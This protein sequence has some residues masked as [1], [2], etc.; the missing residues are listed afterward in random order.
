MVI[1]EL[2]PPN[3][4]QVNEFP[5]NTIFQQLSNIINNYHF[6]K[7]EGQK[8]LRSAM[9][10]R[11][12]NTFYI[13][14]KIHKKKIGTRPITASHSYML[15][16]ISSAVANRLQ[17]EVQKYPSIAKNTK[18]VLQRLETTTLP[19]ECFLVTYD[20]ERLYPSINLRQAI[21]IISEN[22]VKN[23][24]DHLWIKLLQ[25]IM[26]NNYVK[27][28]G[29]IYHQTTGT[30]TG[31]QVAPQFANLYLHFLFEKIMNNDAILFNSRYIDD[32]FMIIKTNQD[33][34]HILNQINNISNLNITYEIHPTSAIYLDLTI[35]KGLRF[36]Y[37]N[38]LDVTTYFKPTN[39]LLY[40]PYSSCHPDHMKLGIAKGEAIRLLRNNCHKN[41]WIKQCTIVF[42]GL[43]AR[44]YPPYKIKSIW[45]TIR[46]EDRNK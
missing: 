21:Q 22:I 28:S 26:F 38:I 11:E 42:K 41:N 31:T 45:K 24:S 39:K 25:L 1:Q 7:F 29:K 9:R 3:F 16:D 34:Q 35:Y 10:K 8:W 44:G 40:L 36:K 46:F 27:Y 5:Y 20:V 12:P 17:Y 15:S 2:Q 6:I 32:G 13:S 14:P 4:Q 37:K 18:S 30:A 43:M 19:Q 23:N 33:A